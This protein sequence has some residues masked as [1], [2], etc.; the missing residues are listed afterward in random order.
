MR[1]KKTYPTR[2]F[3]FLAPAV[4]VLLLVG[5]CPLLF[6]AWH[7]L[8]EFILPRVAR[9]GSPF[10][11]FQNYLSLLTDQSFREALTRTF[12]FL[13]IN[14]PIQLVLGT[15]I[16]LLLH[17]PGNE[18]IK[19]IARVC[20]VI[21]MAT[22]F[23]VVGL[24]GRLMFNSDFGL[25]TYLWNL[26]LGHRVEWLAD[27]NLA[28]ISISIMD[29]W[30][31]TPFCALVL[32]SSLT[33]VPVEIEE[34]ARLETDKWWHV[35]WKVQLPFLLPG[36]TAI[37]ILRTADTL[38]MFDIIFIMTRGGPGSATEL[39][40]IFI[41]RVGFR[42]FDQG[43]ASAQAIVML[44]ISIVLSRIYIRFLYREI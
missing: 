30:Q 1:K 43:M 12:V 11:W 44:V 23:A 4:I 39:I 25:I 34:A 3:F 10:V 35:L 36:I 6:A 31:W 37:L 22:T 13:L 38:R 26:I 29:C 16:A 14:L 42:A 20:L 28:F 21:P 5:I 17:K 40:S 8:H 41:Q 19:N 15:A 32:L 24:M 27:P 9:Y 2:A 18:L 7:S 33:M